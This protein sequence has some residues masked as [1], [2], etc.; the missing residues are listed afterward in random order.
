MQ[1]FSWTH[2]TLKW[3]FMVSSMLF[4]TVVC[5]ESTP[6]S[7]AVATFSSP[8]SYQVYNILAAEIYV[9]QANPGQ[10]AL[11]YIAVAQQAKDASLAQRAAELATMADD[12]QLVSRA[13]ELW[14]EIDP[15][16][17]EARQYRA[18]SHVQAGRYEA[19]VK[20]FV[21]IRDQMKKKDGGGFELM[22]SL[23][24][25]QRDAQHAYGTLKHYVDTVDQSASAQLALAEMANGSDHFD[26]AISAAQVAK[27]SGT[28]PQKEQAS[29]LI[30]EALMGLKQ[31][32]KALDE[33]GPVAHASKDW[34]LKLSYGR[35]L[36]LTDRR[37]EATPL[38][39]QL[40]A[41][42]PENVDIL[43]TL[44]L[45]HLEQKQF[46]V[47]EP[48]IKKLQEVPER[49]ND[50]SYFLGQIHEGQK[51]TKDAIAAYKQAAQGTFAMESARRLTALLFATEGLAPARAWIHEYL[52]TVSNEVHKARLLVMEGKLLH[53]QKQYAEAE[54]VFAQA[55]TVNPL[56]ADALYNR[57]LS[58]ERLGR[59][60]D[61]EKDLRDVM[62]L[63]PDN[64]SVLNALG[65]MLMTNT[66][67]YTE[68][69]SLI[70]KAIVL[71]PDDAPVMDSMGWILFRTGKAE[72]AEAWLRKA[73]EHLPDPEIA[74]HLVEVLLARGKADDAK[75]L[76]KDT[77]AKFPDDP[78][79][80]KLKDKLVG[81]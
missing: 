67:R 51:R 14:A 49:A 55:L 9:R 64:A 79:L 50:A 56:D 37:S 69:E 61:A 31:P 2:Q 13:L 25:I 22:V 28:K 29:R 47:A 46:N 81:L 54:K 63:Q 32:N 7:T 8:I 26:E 19:A 38:Y 48:L 20:D 60:A 75:R 10:A 5:A 30:A 42:Q 59:F 78:L 3:V 62:S 71:A 80:T 34:D 23:L 45:L 33:F 40:Y 68:A 66:E 36:I 57:A 4:G 21:V 27:K 65:Y 72:E 35:M 16:S 44:G 11:H 12:A 24:E 73:Y 17:L 76:L 77:L 43:Y 15:N 74:G 39:Q 53:E 1:R 18:L 6:A 70:R 41:K 52:P 58:T